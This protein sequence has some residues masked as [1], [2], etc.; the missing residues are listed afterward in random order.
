MIGHPRR[1]RADRAGT[2][3]RA[4][5]RAESFSGKRAVGSSGR[6][7][8]P[9]LP[10]TD[11]CRDGGR[12]PNADSATRLAAGAQGAHFPAKAKACIV[13]FMYGGVSQVDTFDPK[14]ELARYHGK[15]IPTLDN[16]P[17]SKGRNPGV[18]LGSTRKFARHG[19]AGIAVSDLYPNFAR[20]VD[21]VAIIRSMYA[22]SFAHGS[23]LAADEHRALCARDIRAWARGSRTGWAR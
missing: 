7:W 22:D 21:D 13:L 10:A 2:D 3:S 11:S 9:C 18:L 5:A 6:R 20:C 12:R 17:V 8:R 16:D 23:G 14:P 15:P 1:P 4:A 19:Q